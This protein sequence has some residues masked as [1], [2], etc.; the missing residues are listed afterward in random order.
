MFNKSTKG[1]KGTNGGGYI[2]PGTDIILPR[3]PKKPAK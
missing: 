2:V 3:P 1:T